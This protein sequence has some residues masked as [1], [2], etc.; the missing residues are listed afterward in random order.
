MTPT[1]TRES[2]SLPTGSDAGSSL[3]GQ[4]GDDYGLGELVQSLHHIRQDM[5]TDKFSTSS[6]DFEND[7]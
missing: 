3:N 7:I 1:D 5:D 6:T 4:G 2:S